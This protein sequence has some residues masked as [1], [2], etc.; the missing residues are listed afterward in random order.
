IARSHLVNAV[1]DTNAKI[2]S[3]NLGTCLG[4]F[5]GVRCY[6]ADPDK[7]ALLGVEDGLEVLGSG[8][9][10]FGGYSSGLLVYTDF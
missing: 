6:S 5:T 9:A 7:Y 1:A 4:L 10:H 2:K 3:G 8:T